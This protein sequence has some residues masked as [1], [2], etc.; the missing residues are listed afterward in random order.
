MRSARLECAFRLDIPNVPEYVVD[1]RDKPQRVEGD[2]ET[3]RL[4]SRFVGLTNATSPVPR[5]TMHVSHCIDADNIIEHTV[6]KNEWKA[7]HDDS[8]DAELGSHVR[9]RWR[10][11]GKRHQQLRRSLH[12][13]I[14]PYAAAG[15]LV[16]VPIGGCV[17]LLACRRRKLDVFH[18]RF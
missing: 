7:A 13:G 2:L 16:L 9:I 4:V 10:C 15:V 8:T 11:G 17:E 6:D 1:T 5:A 18:D 12:G 3:T 14:E